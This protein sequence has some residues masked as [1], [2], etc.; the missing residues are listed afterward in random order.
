MPS[1]QGNRETANPVV[2]GG[3]HGLGSFLRQQIGQL[4]SRAGPHIQRGRLDLGLGRP[5]HVLQSLQQGAE[6]EGVEQSPHGVVVPLP[7]HAGLW[8]QVQLQVAVQPGQLLVSDEVLSGGL[9]GRSD[10]ALD[11]RGPVEEFL[12]TAE[13]LH[14]LGGGLLPDPGDAGDVV[15]RVTL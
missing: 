1:A 13:V 2:E 8:I 10:A 4:G 3:V 7:H 15:G 12:H 6:F 11:L 5:L 14:Q 9:D